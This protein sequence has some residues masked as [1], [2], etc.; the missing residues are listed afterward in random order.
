MGLGHVIQHAA[1]QCGSGSLHFRAATIHKPSHNRNCNLI[2]RDNDMCNSKSPESPQKM[3]LPGLVIPIHM[4]LS[5]A[6]GENVGATLST[7]RDNDASAS[8]ADAHE[9]AY[10]ALEK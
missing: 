10:P 6:E 4:D 7:S 3:T 5:A 9:V 2:E 8:I 1:L